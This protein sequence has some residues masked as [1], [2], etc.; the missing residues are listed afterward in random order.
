VKG[1]RGLTLVELLMG[2]FLLVLVS[3]ALLR[4][5]TVVSRGVTNASTAAVVQGSV[6]ETAAMLQRFLASGDSRFYAFSGRG[7]L[8][9]RVLFRVLTP[10]PGRCADLSLGCGADTAFLYSHYDRSLSPAVTAICRYSGTEWL[11]DA[12]NDTYGR[13]QSV[14]GGFEVLAPASGQPATY[15]IGKVAIQRDRLL[16]LANPPSFTLW[17][18]T[19]VP[20]RHNV[21]QVG[22][23]FVPPLPGDCVSGLRLDAGGNPDLSAL[24]RVSIRP[25][26]LRQLTGGT[27]VTAPEIAAAEGRFPM[28]LFNASLRTFG[29]LATDPPRF[30]VRG[31]VYRSGNLACA[32]TLPYDVPGVTRVRV[33]ES[34]RTVLIPD[35]AE[36]FEVV[37]LGGISGAVCA[38][39]SNECRTLIEPTPIQMKV[40]LTAQ[41]T[42]AR[43]SSAAFSLIK[44]DLIKTLKVRL[45]MARRREQFLVSFP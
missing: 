7:A 4:L 12:G 24:Y 6:N 43:P 37:G 20:V 3:Y 15:P 32:E 41:E 2:G 45:D 17:A 39:P 35:D 14:A 10:L 5:L 31:C 30:A 36:E 8:G 29:K 38:V 21:R 33:N 25:L 19:A 26:I 44:Q 9:D 11:V 23:N 27:A 34:F 13:A 40:Q 42:Y 1:T 22:P 28:R 16:A 18:A